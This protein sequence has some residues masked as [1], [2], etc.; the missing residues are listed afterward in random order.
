MKK[1]LFAFMLVLSS[2]IVQA[3]DY[4]TYNSMWVNYGD[5]AKLYQ[6]PLIDSM[7]YEYDGDK[8]AQCIWHDGTAYRSDAST[9]S[10]LI[11]FNPFTPCIL[12]DTE[13][14]GAWD[15]VYVTPIGYFAFKATVPYAGDDIDTEAYSVLSFL[16]FNGTSHCSMAFDGRSGIPLWADA[17]TAALYF[18][19]MVDSLCSID[20]YDSSQVQTIGDYAFS[21]KALVEECFSSGFSDNLKRSLFYMTSLTD[22]RLGNYQ[23][24]RELMEKF[25]NL[26]NTAYCTDG[27]VW[28]T[29]NTSKNKWPMIVSVYDSG[30]EPTGNT[31]YSVVVTTGSYRNL[32]SN[33]CTAEGAL[34]CAYSG[35]NARCKYGILCD[36]NPDN[37]IVGKA[38]FDIPGVQERL[39]LSFKVDISGLKASTKYYYRAYCK[40]DSAKY[41]PLVVKFDNRNPNEIIKRPHYVALETYGAIKSFTTL[42]PDISGQWTCI[43]KHYD[44]AGNPKYRT[45]S[46]TLND[47]GTVTIPT[48]DYLSASWSYSSSGN[49]SIHALSY[50]IGDNNGGFDIYCTADDP[51][52]PKEFKGRRTPWNFNSVVGSVT[53]DSYGIT[54]TK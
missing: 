41:G 22:G 37:L 17:D 42:P 21:E 1:I 32:E 23:H 8:V 25:K 54:L 46:I 35:Y 34:R 16:D 2:W 33:S 53:G 44:N 15:E 12:K 27:K 7:T 26:L 47:D 40:L 10:E 4:S 51:K 36:E 39:S 50:A 30:K 13:Y 20:I 9:V 49:L 52:D 6:C 14:S 3:Q 24:L 29:S 19:Y 43:E 38:Q 28:A 18:S 5:S 45:Y 31:R 11:F 48:E